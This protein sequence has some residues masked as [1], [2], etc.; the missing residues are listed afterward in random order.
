MGIT[1][2]FGYIWLGHLSKASREK[3]TTGRI[4]VYLRSSVHNFTIDAS[5]GF[6]N[7]FKEPF[8]KLATSKAVK[9][10]SNK[11]LQLKE[12]RKNKIKKGRDVSLICMY[13]YNKILETEL[14]VKNRNIFSDSSGVHEV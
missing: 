2:I 1:V 11:L 6:G 14:F 10:G 7:D 3:Y 9:G 4:E 8:Q 13:C 5:L 12:E